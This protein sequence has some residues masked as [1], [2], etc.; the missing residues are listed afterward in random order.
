MRLHRHL[1]D[2]P[3]LLELKRW[4][5]PTIYNAWEQI[6][7]RNPAEGAFNLEE[8]RDF[9]PQMGPMV[10][11][12]VNIL[13]VAVQ[14]GSSGRGIGFAAMACYARSAKGITGMRNKVRMIMVRIEQATCHGEPARSLEVGHAAEEQAEPTGAQADHEQKGAAD[15]RGAIG[16]PTGRSMSGNR[17]VS[18]HLPDS[19]SSELN[20][21]TVPHPRSS[22]VFQ[23]LGSRA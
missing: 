23:G 4:N 7:R 18:K 13:S 19:Y 20:A 16:I 11:Y 8:T 17:S 9:M 2:H 10:G 5:I 12:A 6:T 15:L 22:F 1:L 21:T 14:A 3:D